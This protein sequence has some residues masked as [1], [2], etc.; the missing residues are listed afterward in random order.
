M[1]LQ[2]WWL[3]VA[4]IFLLSATPGPNM[5]HIMAR[6][7]DQGFARSVAAMAGCL[8]A[9]MLVLAASAMGLIALL[10]LIPGLFDILRAAGIAYLVWLGVKAWRAEVQPLDPEATPAPA[11][12]T[13]RLFRGGFAISISNPKLILFAVAFLPQFITPAVPKAPQFAIILA[14]FAVIEMFWYL[15]YAGA[16]HAIARL[17]TR[18]AWRRAFNRLTGVIFIGFALALLKVRPA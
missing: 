17:L 16:G 7:A 11:L 2:N 14:T 10:L 9:I 4:A 6:S 3:F 13:G 1:T 5:L 8:A 12:S 15:I 18:P